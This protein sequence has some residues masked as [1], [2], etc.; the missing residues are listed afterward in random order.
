MLPP[1]HAFQGRQRPHLHSPEP[2]DEAGRGSG[3]IGL[4]LV[5]DHR[6]GCWLAELRLMVL[7]AAGG[8]G[9]RLGDRRGP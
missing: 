7:S 4:K 6:Q 2:P 1:G 3:E 9:N 8:G 5:C